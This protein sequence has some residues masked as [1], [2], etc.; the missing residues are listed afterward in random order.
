VNSRKTQPTKRTAWGDALS[1]RVWGH[2][3]AYAEDDRPWKCEATFRYLQECLDFIAYC[4][5][6]GHDVVFQSPAECK[7]IKASD[8][9]VVCV[10]EIEDKFAPCRTIAWT[11]DTTKTASVS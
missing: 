9:R 2:D 6:R 5:D 7:L 4:Q 1:Y 3:P 8:R 10:P 11:D